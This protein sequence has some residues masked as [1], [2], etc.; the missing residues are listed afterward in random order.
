MEDIGS[1]ELYNAHKDRLYSVPMVPHLS[2]IRPH[3]QRSSLKL[4]WSIKVNFL[5][6]ASIGRGNESVFKSHDQ[7]GHIQPYNLLQQNQSSMIFETWHVVS[8]TRI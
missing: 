4:F 7:D 1:S 5:Y 6:E 3:F 2:F 8:E